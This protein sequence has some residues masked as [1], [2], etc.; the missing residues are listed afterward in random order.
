MVIS[1]LK[2]VRDIEEEYLKIENV[3]KEEQKIRF[4]T[5]I[6]RSLEDTSKILEYLRGGEIVL[7]KI[8]DL[9]ERDI[10]E[11]KRVIDKFKKTCYAIE[12]DIVGI[13]EDFVLLT[14]SKISI[15]RGK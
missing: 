4:R 5:E 12:G 1:K 8:K 15:F 11:L 13:D 7:V 3:E 2:A 10:V 6:L 9:R 14:P